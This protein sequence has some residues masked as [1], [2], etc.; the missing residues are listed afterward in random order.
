MAAVPE[1]QAGRFQASDLVG[2]VQRA[3]RVLEVVASSPDGLTAKAVARRA[4]MALSTTYHLLNTLAAEGYVVH[5][6]AGRGYGLGHQVSVLSRSLRQKLGATPTDAAVTEVHQQ[7]GAAACSAVYRS[8]E[9]IIAHVADSPDAPFDRYLE[10]TLSGGDMLGVILAH[11]GGDDSALFLLAFA[12]VGLIFLIGF[13]IVLR[14]V[15]SSIG[16]REEDEDDDDDD[17]S[18]A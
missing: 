12:P 9:V 3:L 10:P 4:N 6:G 8:G 17:R 15:V 7:S 13:L 1:R 14:P 16:E 5:L 2:S 18:D 11:G